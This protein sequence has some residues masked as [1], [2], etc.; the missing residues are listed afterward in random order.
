MSLLRSFR[1]NRATYRRYLRIEAG[2][3]IVEILRDL[4]ISHSS[5]VLIPSII[6]HFTNSIHG[7]I[8]SLKTFFYLMY[9]K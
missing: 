5:K 1:E 2:K 6:Y 3:P 4:R 8:Q 7:I 9:L